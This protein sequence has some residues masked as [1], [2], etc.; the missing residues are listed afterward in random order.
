M[1]K[2]LKNNNSNTNSN[3]GLKWLPKVGK[4]DRISDQSNIITGKE[5]HTYTHTRTQKITLLFFYTQY[6]S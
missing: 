1:F 3:T 4:V 2:M 6:I 5:T